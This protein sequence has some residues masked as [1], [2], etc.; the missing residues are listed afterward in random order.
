MQAAGSTRTQSCTIIMYREYCQPLQSKHARR[1]P[2]PQGPS[3]AGM[4]LNGLR[5]LV[6]NTPLEGPARSLC[7][8]VLRSRSPDTAK[9]S[10]QNT[11]WDLRDTRDQ[12]S[13]ERI[14]RTRLR[15]D[16]NGIDI[17]AHSGAFLQY[18]LRLAPQGQHMAFEPIPALADLLRRE[19]PTVDVRECALSNL[20]GRTSFVYLPTL[21]AWSG[22]R[23]QPCPADVQPQQVEVEVRR[24]DDLVPHDRIIDFIK[25]DVEGAELE[26]LE[27]AK[28]TIRRTRPQVL[29]EHAK[30]HNTHYDTTPASV[31]GLLHDECGLDVQLL[32]DDTPLTME[33]FASIYE[34]SHAS[35]YDRRAQTNFLARPA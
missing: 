6:K 14:L 13:F 3:A 2:A 18:Y 21:P 26:V 9:R 4:G 31:W 22:L 35:G 17:G 8:A 7:R 16:S 25:I 15:P 28:E 30:I 12:V 11:E 27:G 5:R 10:P 20:S 1:S 29:F 33:A 19:F 32:D 34:R 24:L 23:P